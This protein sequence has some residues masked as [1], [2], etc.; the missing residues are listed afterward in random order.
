[1]GKGKRKRERQERREGKGRLHLVQ[2]TRERERI[3]A[4]ALRNGPKAKPSP[5]AR[6]LQDPHREEIE[7]AQM[8]AWREAGSPPPMT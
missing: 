3:A 4:D 2:T 5:T 7:A 6:V 8:Q 1:M